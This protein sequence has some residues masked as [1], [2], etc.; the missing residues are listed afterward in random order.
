MMKLIKRIGKG[1]IVFLLLGSLIIAFFYRQEAYRLYKVVTFFEPESISENFRDIESI[2]PIRLVQ[3][4]SQPYAFPYA[5][6]A[7]ILPKNFSHNDSVINTQFYLDYTLTDAL[8]VIQNDSIKH[9]Y[10]SN[11]FQPTDTHISFSMAKSV[12]S[13]LIGIAIEE[14]YIK[15]IKNTVTEYLPEFEGTGYDG[16]QIKDVLQMSSGVKFNEDYSDFY[17]DINI[18]GRYFAI[19]KPMRKFAKTLIR[20]REPGTYNQY[21]SIDTQVLGMILTKATGM[22]ISEYMYKKLWEPIGAEFDAFWI[23]DNEG[24]EFALGGLNC[25]AKDYAK[26]G[27]LFLNLG[28]WK[29]KQLVPSEWVKASITPDAPHL[30]PGKRTNAKLKEGYGYQWW[31]PLGALDEFYA[32]GIYTQF[33]YVDPD[34]DMVIVKLSSNYHFKTD[35]THFFRDHELTL[36]RTIAESL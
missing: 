31:I 9:E 33:I 19:G 11:G 35:T 18:M 5:N 27:Q 12:I 28:H 30:M 22:S 34:K 26:M 6:K 2:F 23:I 24:M 17:S 32:Q 36:Y 15:S 14:G 3:K 20:E 13:T 1:I 4:S 29:G 25:T 10:Y 8:L 21:V 7:H 16:V